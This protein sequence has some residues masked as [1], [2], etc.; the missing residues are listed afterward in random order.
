[1]NQRVSVAPPSRTDIIN[2]FQNSSID[3]DGNSRIQRDEFDRL[4]A[5]LVSRIS[6]RVAAHQFLTFVAAPTLAP[7]LVHLFLETGKDLLSQA[8]MDSQFLMQVLVPDAVLHETFWSMALTV[9]MVSTLGNTVLEEA[10]S[11]GLFR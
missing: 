7:T 10:A 6:T 9:C 3:L 8:I 11:E 4:V 5:A 1:M 2:L